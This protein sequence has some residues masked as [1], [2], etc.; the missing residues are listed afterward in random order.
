M[1]RSEKHLMSVS[2]RLCRFLPSRSPSIMVL[3]KKLIRVVAWK[4]GFST[5][6]SWKWILNFSIDSK[7][8]CF[9]SI[10]HI[11]FLFIN[12]TKVYFLQ[13][14]L[15]ITVPPSSNIHQNE[16]SFDKPANNKN[17]DWISITDDVSGN[18]SYGKHYAIFIMFPI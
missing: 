7:T 4:L 13:F 17:T 2:S 8:V 18:K 16:S 15:V 10:F 6:L 1:I 11:Q 12:E 14:D 5:M 3:F 9:Y